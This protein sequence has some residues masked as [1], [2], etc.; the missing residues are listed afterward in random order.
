VKLHVF[1][2]SRVVDGKRVIGKTYSGRYRLPGDLKDRQVAL[3]IP[4]KQAAKAA[5]AARVKQEMLEFHGLVPPSR[6]LETASSPILPVVGEWLD[7]LRAKGRKPHYIGI[8]EKFW[9]VLSRE[10]GWRRVADV[11]ADSFIRWRV[12][13]AS[14]K[15]AKTLNEYLGAV[16]AFFN[17]LVKTGRMP[18]NPMVSVE[19]VE[20]R[21]K[22]V[23]NRRSF[24]H[25]EF[26]RMIEVAESSRSIVYAMAY[27]TGL[28]RAELETLFWSDF[29]LA[30]DVPTV[31]IHA[32]DTK[33]RQAA[34]LPL[35]SDLRDMLL[36]H[37]RAQG[38]PPA[39][40]KALEVPK[41]LRAFERDLKAA[42]IR[43]SD[44]RGRILDFHSFRH[45]CA[46]RLASS[47]TPLAVAMKIMRHSDPRLTAKVYVD[48]A[49]L[50]LA[51]SIEKLP[52]MT[53]DSL[54]LI[55]S[56]EPVVSGQK[57]SPPVV[58]NQKEASPQ[59]GFNELLRRVL[60]HLDALKEMA[61]AVGIE[62]TT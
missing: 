45:S 30:A 52:G 8:M 41:R 14:E 48:D 39:S 53:P 6:Q 21:G 55:H 22:T 57:Q 1:K 12:S 23:R 16:R 27:Y 54:S 19:N 28:R 60:S 13:N 29:N 2:P 5:L 25:P 17:W 50:P 37:Q 18:A 4:D 10:C 33:N 56:L 15:S 49:A 47:G 59:L 7:D 38:N 40:S 61:P 3:D 31:T 24:T 51:A 11:R 32:T 26:L 35:H 46:T 20:V 43:K 62:P 36:A 9:K 34:T 58:S 42:G 44:E